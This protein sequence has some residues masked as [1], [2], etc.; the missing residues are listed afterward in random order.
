MGGVTFAGVAV[1]AA[2]TGGSHCWS[3]H[4]RL[5]CGDGAL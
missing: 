4:N 2:G 5:G 1:D 3:G